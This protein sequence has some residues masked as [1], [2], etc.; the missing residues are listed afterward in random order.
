MRGQNRSR[1]SALR[2]AVAGAVL[3]G[4]LVSAVGAFSADGVPNIVPRVTGAAQPMQEVPAP[5]LA[6][7]ITD[8]KRTMRLNLISHLLSLI[9]YEDLPPQEKVKLPPRQKRSY[10]RP[11]QQSQNFVPARYVV[12]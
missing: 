7:P 9:P 4:A 10:V 3:G 6:R 8:D 5:P 12:K 2:M 1:L 11:P